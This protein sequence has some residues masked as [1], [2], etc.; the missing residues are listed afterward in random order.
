[1]AYANGGGAFFLPYLVALLSAGLPVLVLEYTLGHRF[2]GPA[3]PSPTP[4]RG[5]VGHR[6]VLAG[7]VLAS[8]VL[9][10]IVL[11]LR[12]WDKRTLDLSAHTEKADAAARQEVGR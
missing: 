12:P 3:P 9:A 5:V 1:M 2:R 10:G 7:A 4:V 11:A 6:A 8:I